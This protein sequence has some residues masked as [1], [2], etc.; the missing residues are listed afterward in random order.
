M[1]EVVTPGLISEREKMGW[2]AKCKLCQTI[3]RGVGGSNKGIQKYL[4]W[5]HNISVLCQK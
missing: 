5:M 2:S 3:L 1:A 4:T